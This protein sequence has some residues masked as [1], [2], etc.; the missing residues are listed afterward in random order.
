MLSPSNSSPTLAYLLGFDSIDYES[1]NDITSIYGRVYPLS[2]ISIGGVYLTQEQRYIV[3]NDQDDSGLFSVYAVSRLAYYDQFLFPATAPNYALLNL[4]DGKIYNLFNLRRIIPWAIKFGLTSRSGNDFDSIFVSQRPNNTVFPSSF[5]TLFSALQ[6]NTKLFI[7]MDNVTAL[8]N[9]AL[10]TST[11]GAAI[12]Y[13]AS[14]RFD[15]ESRNYILEE[16]YPFSF[17]GSSATPS[18]NVFIIDEFGLLYNTR[19]LQHTITL[20]FTL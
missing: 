10:Y 1:I 11:T 12:Q 13:V 20:Q 6:Q 18:T 7:Y 19:Q 4:P 9:D 3:Q 16:S 15:D 17:N 8:T 5:L 2:S 14:L